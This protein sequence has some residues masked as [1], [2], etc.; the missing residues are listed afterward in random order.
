[1][2][3]GIHS[4]S[5]SSLYASCLKRSQE[6]ELQTLEP[7]A[8]TCTVVVVTVVSCC[9]S[10]RCKK[11][12]KPMFGSGNLEP[13]SNVSNGALGPDLLKYLVFSY[14]SCLLLASLWCYL[15][16][17]MTSCLSTPSRGPF[18]HVVNHCSILIDILFY[19]LSYVGSRLLLGPPKGQHRIKVSHKNVHLI[20]PARL[21]EENFPNLGL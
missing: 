2:F 21:S 10:L 11:H 3:I 13:A 1:M 12:Q 20:S 4:T 9:V 5:L 8:S 19:L 17:L 6:S 7:R 14:P 15:L 16:I 18:E